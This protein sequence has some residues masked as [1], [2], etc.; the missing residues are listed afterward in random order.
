MR[1][2]GSFLSLEFDSIALSSLC[3]FSRRPSRQWHAANC[4]VDVWRFRQWFEQET[5]LRFLRKGPTQPQRLPHLR[6]ILRLA[7]VDRL[8]PSA[9]SLC[10]WA[11]NCLSHHLVSDSAKRG[12]ENKILGFGIVHLPC[13]TILLCSIFLSHNVVLHPE[14]LT[15]LKMFGTISVNIG[16]EFT[17]NSWTTHGRLN[18]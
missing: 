14:S 4:L 12:N 9:E 6:H 17:K 10:R 15:V 7:R 3:P 2:S 11:R 16:V 5:L 13:Y 1:D 18:G 8:R